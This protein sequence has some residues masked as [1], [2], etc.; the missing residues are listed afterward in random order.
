[1]IPFPGIIKL[2]K[3]ILKTAWKNITIR[4]TIVMIRPLLVIIA[5]FYNENFAGQ[6]GYF[7]IVSAVITSSLS[8]AYYKKY[9]P[10]AVGKGITNVINDVNRHTILAT[11]IISILSMILSIPLWVF[12][13][14]M[15]EFYFH[16]IAR[17]YLYRKNFWLWGIFSILIPLLFIVSYFI[18][19]NLDLILEKYIL[20]T[21]FIISLIY[22]AFSKLKQLLSDIWSNSIL[23]G[24]SRKII[25]QLDKLIIGYVLDPSNFWIIAILYQISNAGI[26]LFDTIVVMPNKNKMVKNEFVYDRIGFLKINSFFTILSFLFLLITCFLISRENIIFLIVFCTTI[27]IRIFNLNYFNL[28]LEMFFWKYELFKISK[29]LIGLTVIIFGISSMLL[30]VLDDK[31]GAIFSTI[32]YIIFIAIITRYIGNKVLV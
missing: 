20:L 8:F 19:L 3:K 16:Q 30:Y 24:I 13:A 6:L 15:F 5:S 11:S 25:T 2:R 31:I 12:F 14:F 1:M 10:D 21:V 9:M 32:I 18:F 4:F 29:I 22:L 23:F 26:V 7:F 17:I 28:K 27:S